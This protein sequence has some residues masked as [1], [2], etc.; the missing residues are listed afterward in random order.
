MKRTPQIAKIEFSNE[1][2]NIKALLL[3]SYKTF[4]AAELLL[5]ESTVLS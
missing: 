5:A 4:I 1:T 2:V 3:E